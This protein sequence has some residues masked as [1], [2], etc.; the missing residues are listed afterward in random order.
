[1]SEAG[2]PGARA[3]VRCEAASRPRD[4]ERWRGESGAA[5]PTENDETSLVGEQTRLG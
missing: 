1:M 4:R 2:A 3:L 5:T